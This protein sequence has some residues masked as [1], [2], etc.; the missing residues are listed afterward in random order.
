[1]KEIPDMMGPFCNECL[2]KGLEGHEAWF[3]TRDLTHAQE[4]AERFEE[5]DWEGLQEDLD[6]YLESDE[7]SEREDKYFRDLEEPSTLW[8]KVKFWWNKPGLWHSYGVHIVR[9][10]YCH[11]FIKIG[12]GW[13]SIW[14]STWC[15]KT[16]EDQDL[17][18]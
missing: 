5:E 11:K 16:C 15:S 9:C 18:F 12:W 13:R 7:Y 10:A 17:P 3:D 14:C 4:Q 6:D 1:M 2:K 8:E